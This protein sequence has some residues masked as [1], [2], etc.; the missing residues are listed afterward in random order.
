[1]KTYICHHA[2]LVDR[3]I[4][5][6]AQIKACGME[7]SEWVER[8]P[9]V[10]DDYQEILVSV[11]RKYAY[12]LVD[13][14]NLGDSHFLILEDDVD[15][16]E[17]FLNILDKC[18]DEF[19]E[20]KGEML[21]LGLAQENHYI[22]TPGKAIHYKPNL[23]TRCC[24]AI[25]Y[26]R[27]CALKIVSEKSFWNVDM[28]IDHKLNDLIYKLELKHFWYE[29]GIGQAYYKMGSHLDKYRG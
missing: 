9:N 21:S 11:Q 2:P 13:G 4:I 12:C 25:V 8:Y 22:E 26:S 1:M 15:L 23:M 27:E 10:H 17:N 3:K 28:A 24:H 5:L 14:I 19:I 7:G 29:P 6:S 20:R 18:M 16:P